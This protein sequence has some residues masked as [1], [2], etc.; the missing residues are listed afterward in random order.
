MNIIRMRL[1]FRHAFT[2]PGFACPQQHLMAG[3]PPPMTDDYYYSKFNCTGKHMKKLQRGCSWRC[4][5]LILVAVCVILL[6]CTLYFSGQCQVQSSNV[7]L[8]SVKFKV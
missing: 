8:V 2:H 6:A 4:T 7:K 1:F 3:Y 5:A